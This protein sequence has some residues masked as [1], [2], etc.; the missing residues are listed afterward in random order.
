MVGLGYERRHLDVVRHAHRIA[1]GEVSGERIGDGARIRRPVLCRRKRRGSHHEGVHVSGL[2]RVR[3]RARARVRARVRVR[4]RAKA[5]ARARARARAK[6]GL[7]VGGAQDLA[8]DPAQPVP[9]EDAEVVAR[10]VEPSDASYTHADVVPVGHMFRAGHLVLTP[11]PPTPSTTT[12]TT[13]TTPTPTPTKILLLLLR[14]RT[15]GSWRRP[16][17]SVRSHPARRGKYKVS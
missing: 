2:L 16:L 3:A 7:G 13:T 4:V 14:C 8:I 17:Q 9:L 10:V 6:A 1:R 15:R 5:R 11:T 12:T